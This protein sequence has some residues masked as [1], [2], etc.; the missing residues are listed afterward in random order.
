MPKIRS[1]GLKTYRKKAETTLT[2]IPSIADDPL[3]RPS[4]MIS[5]PTGEMQF[6]E[7]QQIWN[8][9]LSPTP[10]LVKNYTFAMNVSSKY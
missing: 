6:S 7:I 9:I 5:T 3:G 10:Q 1:R 4:L 2:G 8:R